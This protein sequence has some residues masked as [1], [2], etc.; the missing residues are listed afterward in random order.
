MS[1]SGIFSASDLF[2]TVP[3]PLI[4]KCFAY[5]ERICK[6]N[7][8]IESRTG[9]AVSG[10]DQLWFLQVFASEIHSFLVLSKVVSLTKA[11][12]PT[13]CFNEGHQSHW[14]Q[15]MG[16]FIV[17]GK[18]LPNSTTENKPLKYNLK[19]YLLAPTL[20]ILTSSSRIRSPQVWIWNRVL[21]PKVRKN[22]VVQNRRVGRRQCV[23]VQVTFLATLLVFSNTVPL[24]YAWQM[25][26]LHA[27]SK[28]DSAAK[29]LPKTLSP[30]CWDCGI[31]TQ[32]PRFRSLFLTSAEIGTWH[33]LER[34]QWRRTR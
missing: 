6:V 18:K 13:S 32:T 26:G 30:R 21:S 31:K 23:W 17:E 7:R 4:V 22:R 25:P 19:F 34:H 24:S 2:I 12:N 5:I 16:G 3:S 9:T 1:K 33:F 15:S 27:L 14:T 8:T 28:R 11:I 10:L 20:V 29:N